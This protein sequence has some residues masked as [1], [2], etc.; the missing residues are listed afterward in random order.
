MNRKSSE[1]N[2]RKLTKAGKVSLSLTIPRELAVELGWRD[3]QKVVV[4]K[5]GQGIVIEDWKE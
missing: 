3:N 2:I 4:K 1:K 5:R